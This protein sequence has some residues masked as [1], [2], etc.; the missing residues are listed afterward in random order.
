[1]RT[2]FIRSSEKKRIEQ[3]LNG[4]FGISKLPFLLLE[5]GKEKIRGFSGH[6]SKEEIA[7]ISHSLNVETVGLYLIK[8]EEHL[9][10]SID[11]IHLL[12]NQIDKGVV[13]INEEETK[14][15]IRGQDIEKKSEKGVVLIKTDDYFLGSG[16]SNGE[17]IFNYL[18]KE[19]RLKN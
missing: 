7:L 13:D 16:K 17:I 10:L 4:Q 3:E 8:R 5:S 2:R 6:L 19:R 15:W 9:R 14:K 11:A 12:K 18:P 1:M